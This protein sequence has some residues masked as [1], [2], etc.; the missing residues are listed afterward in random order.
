MVYPCKRRFENIE[1][2][3]TN[4]KA[5]IK[6][7]IHTYFNLKQGIAIGNYTDFSYSDVISTIQQLEKDVNESILDF[8]VTNLEFGFNIQTSLDAKS[9]L[10]NN[11]VMYNF[12]EF[13]Q[14]DTFKGKGYYKQYNRTQY[15]VKLYDKALQFKLPCNL[16]RAE[17]K[18][19]DSK[20]LKKFGIFTVKDISRKD[21]LYRLFSFF[22]QC[23]EQ[24]NIVDRFSTHEIDGD[25][26]KLIELGKSPHYWRGIKQRLSLIHI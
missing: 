17:I 19:K 13:S 24:I 4:T 15:Y 6:N 25:E 5:I 16:L 7:S 2:R 1:V 12:D 23:F 10:E 22:L 26:K 21:C 14:I 11:F 8:K 3:I 18:I 9:I 20:L